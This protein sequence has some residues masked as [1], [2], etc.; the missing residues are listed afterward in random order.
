MILAI[1]NRH[2]LNDYTGLFHA[3]YRGYIIFLFGYECN[4]R[5]QFDAFFYIVEME[6]KMS[7]G[8]GGGGWVFSLKKR[9]FLFRRMYAC[10][11]GIYKPI[12]IAY[13]IKYFFVE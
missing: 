13:Q 2:P 1:D 10:V 7:R 4:S 12:L 8:V 6:I 3:S 5:Y 11:H 9:Y